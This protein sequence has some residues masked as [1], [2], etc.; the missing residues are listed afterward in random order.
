[1]LSKVQSVDQ[2]MCR[3]CVSAFANCGRAVAHVRGGY[4]PNIGSSNSL[5]S[6]PRTDKGSGRHETAHCDHVGMPDETNSGCRLFS[7]LKSLRPQQ[8]VEQV[9]QQAGSDEASE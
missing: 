2:R 3:E 8:G 7:A 1:M 6:R 4:V 5:S 9:T